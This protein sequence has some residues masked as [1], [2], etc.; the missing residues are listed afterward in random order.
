MFQ[1]R[2]IPVAVRNLWEKDRRMSKEI[3]GVILAGGRSHRMK[4]DKAFLEIGSIPLI[5]RVL[6]V[7]LPLFPTVAIVAKDLEK[8]YPLKGIRLIPDLLPE[9]HALGGIYTALSTFTGKDCFIFACD[10]PFL[11]PSLIQAMI[12]R[13]NGYDLL[14]PKSRHGLEPLHAIYT[15]KCLPI[16]EKQIHQKRWSL[17]LFVSQLRFNILDPA[18][19]SSVDPEGLAFFNVNTQEE[20]QRAQE[21]QRLFD[22]PWHQ[23][24]LQ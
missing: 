16:M 6:N 8:F 11:N 24:M 22:T 2:L 3:V 12:Q 7:L 13:R 9:Q 21:I 19:L 5:E 10:L 1:R 14:I 20:L 4:T 18:L 23:K 15:G 17:E